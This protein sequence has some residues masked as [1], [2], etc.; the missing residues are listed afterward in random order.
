MKTLIVLFSCITLVAQA[1][2]EF[3][4]FTARDG[5]TLK[6][7]VIT[8]DAGSGK[9]KIE[10]EDGQRISVQRNAF[11]PDDQAYIR[12]WTPCGLFLDASKLTVLPRCTT[13]KKWR[14]KH[15]GTQMGGGQQGG[16]QGGPGGG[17]QGGG[18]GGPGG[19]D[20]GSMGGGSSVLATDKNT[21]YRYDLTLVNRSGIPLGGMKAEYRIFYMQERPVREEVPFAGESNARQGQSGGMQQGT[22]VAQPE[23]QVKR[24]VLE[25]GQLDAGD[26]VKLSTTD[27]VILERN[28]GRQAQGTM[29]DLEATVNG[30]WIKVFMKAPDGSLVERDIALPKRIMKDYR[31]DS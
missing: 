14:R 25:I 10:R 12:Q 18:Q 5:R 19:G 4:E 8:Y 15:E 29:I 3:R 6:A 23:A 11:Q 16:S 9:V 28:A 27:F 2:E 22:F 20:E 13:V 1:A 17:R 31:W 26:R 21:K 7:K 24:G 30:I